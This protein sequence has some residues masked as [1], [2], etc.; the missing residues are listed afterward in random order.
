MNGNTTSGVD[1]N[2]LFSVAP[3]HG[4]QL[5]VRRIYE[6]TT[7]VD[8]TPV[9]TA[10]NQIIANTVSPPGVVPTASVPIEPGETIL[11]TL[12]V[13]GTTTFNPAAAGVVVTAQAKNTGHESDPAV[14][15]PVCNTS[16][17]TLF[18]TSDVPKDVTPPTFGTIPDTTVNAAADATTA[19]VTYN[20]TATDNIGVTTLTCSPASGSV[21]PV[22]T[23]PVTCTASDA[24]GNT[25]TGSFNVVV[26]DVTAPVVA[27]PDD[28]V[29]EATS[30][31]GAAVTFS[32]PN[33]TDAV[34]VKSVSC[35]PASGTTFALGTTTVTCQATDAANNVGS[36]SFTILVRDTPAPSFGAIANVTATTTNTSGTTVTY[37]TPTAADAVGVTSVVCSP[38]SG[39][40]FPIG[41]TTETCTAKD[42]ALNTSTASFTVTVQLSFSFGGFV[43]PATATQGSVVP[44][45][46][47][48]LSGGK[49]VDSSFLV[50]IV[51]VRTLTSCSNGTETG[52]A[53]ID[54]QTPGNS[55]FSYDSKTFTWHWNWQTKP[56]AVGCYNIYVDLTDAQGT[57]LQT[58]GPAKV[59]LK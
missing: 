56:F 26:K 36:S 49:A 20:V 15:P 11:I 12:R 47:Q 39:S 25:A 41:A 35:A 3:P 2:P 53:F 34:G 37:S 14:P 17:P 40:A 52:P 22:G 4:T 43:V 42:A 44:L 18:C 6:G 8:C 46:W 57:L 5:I 38:A 21:F 27:K 48:Y 24:A 1:I 59:R 33:A 13:T 31:A 9:K 45:T 29:V 7:S 32:L 28:K 55:D 19:T 30:A 23:T 50:P 16:D 10:V 54:K 58:N 51:R